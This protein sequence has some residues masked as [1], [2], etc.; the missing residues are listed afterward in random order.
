MFR[1]RDAVTAGLARHQGADNA[2][3]A[4]FAVV[5][6]SRNPL[7]RPPEFAEAV[8]PDSEAPVT[9]RDLLSEPMW[10]IARWCLK[11]SRS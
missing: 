3:R 8:R 5:G 9:L 1:V 2:L 10:T 11:W 7:S 4:G 6:A